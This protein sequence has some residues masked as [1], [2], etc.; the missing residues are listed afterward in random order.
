MHIY[1]GC[2][3]QVTLYE[4]RLGNQSKLY[5]P[6]EQKSKRSGR[7]VMLPCEI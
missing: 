3:G 6:E 1:E 4:N 5:C 7:T 2:V